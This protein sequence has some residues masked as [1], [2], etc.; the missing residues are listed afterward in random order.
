M[1][2]SLL[3]GDEGGERHLSSQVPETNTFN[4]EMKISHL[5]IPQA[6]EAATAKPPEPRLGA[7]RRSEENREVPSV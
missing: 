5:S 4:S 6:E 1:V 2:L 3:A 7:A